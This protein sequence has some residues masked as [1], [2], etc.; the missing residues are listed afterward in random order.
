MSHRPYCTRR[1]DIVNDQIVGALMS[2]P[3]PLDLCR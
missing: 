2:W 3:A 1:D